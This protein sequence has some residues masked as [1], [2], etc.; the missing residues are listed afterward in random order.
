MSQNLSS[1]Q[2]KVLQECSKAF[3]TLKQL[4]QKE[5]S[6]VLTQEEIQAVSQ[7]RDQIKGTGPAGIDIDISSRWVKIAVL[8]LIKIG[9]EKLI[10]KI[11]ETNEFAA[12]VVE[13]L[14]IV[15][16]AMFA[17]PAPATT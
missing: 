16:E 11:R 6:S 1:E 3:E 17:E 9:R 7:L 8:A 13:Q 5:L 4:D 2:Q 15:L 10:P 14:L 12:S